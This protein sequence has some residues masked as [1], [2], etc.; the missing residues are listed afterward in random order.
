M[1]TEDERASMSYGER[2]AWTSAVVVPL[3]ALGYL[4]AVVPQLL[5]HPA[6]QVAWAAPML[7]AMGLTIVASIVGAVLLAIVVRDHE[8][9]LDVRDTQ[10]GRYGDRIALTFTA[11]GA[12][13]VL[14]LAMLEVAYVWIGTSVFLLAA[15]GTT[16]GAI[17]E[18][19]AHR[20]GFVG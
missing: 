14:A 5:A 10:I 11:A 17:A 12:V 16:W 1:R 15:T 9:R 6:D 20:G 3:G 2:Q 8:S 7:W 4:G 18:V 13:V 19:R